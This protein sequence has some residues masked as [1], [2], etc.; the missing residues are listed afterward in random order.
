MIGSSKANEYALTGVRTYQLDIRPDERG[1]V[2]E[3]LR[4][5]WVDFIDEWIVQVNISFGYPNTVRAWHRHLKGQVDYFL[6]LAGALEICA[7][8]EE[9]RRLAEVVGTRDKPMLIRIP[10][11]YY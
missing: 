10:G 5:D 1:F 4:Q 8:D 6:V 9:S 3:A 2:G 11:H 7:Y